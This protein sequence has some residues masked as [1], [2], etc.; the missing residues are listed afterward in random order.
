MIEGCSQF[1]VGHLPFAF[2]TDVLQKQNAFRQ[3]DAHFSLPPVTIVDSLLVIATASLFAMVAYKLLRS[4]FTP[5]AQRRLRHITPADL[6]LARY[7]FAYYP[8]FVSSQEGLAFRHLAATEMAQDER[9]NS[10]FV[11]TYLSGDPEVL[12]LAS[13]G[14]EMLRKQTAAR[15]LRTKGA[16]LF[17]NCCPRCDKLTRTPTARQCR[18]CRFDWHSHP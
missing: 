8:Q 10:W 9:R 17:L 7:L 4:A 15:I 2:I 14:D 16:Q 1:S 5:D 13:Q 6:D 18:F 3:Q 11:S 12:R